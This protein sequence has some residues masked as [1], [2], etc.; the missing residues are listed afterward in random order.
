MIKKRDT[1]MHSHRPRRNPATVKSRLATSQS[2]RARSKDGIKLTLPK[3]PWEME[4]N[5]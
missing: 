2:A 1:P 3:P 5:G 4:R